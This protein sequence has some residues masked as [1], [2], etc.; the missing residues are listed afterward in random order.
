M[1]TVRRHPLLTP[2]TK[3]WQEVMKPAKLG[4]DDPRF[5]WKRGVSVGSC[6]ICGEGHDHKPDWWTGDLLCQSCSLS[7][8]E[9]RRAYFEERYTPGMIE[10][11]NAIR[12]PNSDRMW[13][14]QPYRG[15]R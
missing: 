12:V 6:Q 5:D 10:C 15:G 7:H 1:E 4:G 11:S 13:A 9:A 14:I 2:T 8:V 3:L